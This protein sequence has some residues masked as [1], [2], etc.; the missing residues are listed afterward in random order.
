MGRLEEGW[1]TALPSPAQP[2]CDAAGGGGTGMEIPS[3][4]GPEHPLQPGLSSA[5]GYIR[6]EQ[7]VLHVLLEGANPA[8]AVPVSPPC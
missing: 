2:R 7:V 4:G 6:T 5:R 8:R 1:L 3:A